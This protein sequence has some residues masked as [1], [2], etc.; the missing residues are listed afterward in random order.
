MSSS[1]T[2]VRP[3]T[4][5]QIFFAQNNLLELDMTS[6]EAAQKQIDDFKQLE[7]DHVDLPTPR[8]QAYL[9]RHGLTCDGT[10]GGASAVIAKFREENPEIV[11]AERA[12]VRG[13]AE[14][15]RAARRAEESTPPAAQ[16]REPSAK[17]REYH[18]TAVAKSERSGKEAATIGQIGY[19]NRLAWMSGTPDDRRINALTALKGGASKRHASVLIDQLERANQIRQAA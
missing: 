6:F 18:D 17:V 1:A 7:P 19:L 9:D 12:E 13:K 16:S 4:E 15:T 8:M 11:A 5:R 3:V 14:A 10:Y 2:K